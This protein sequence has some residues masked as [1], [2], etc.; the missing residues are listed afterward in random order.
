[1]TR[2]SKI[3]IHHQ[4]RSSSPFILRVRSPRCT[5][6]RLNYQRNKDHFLLRS[7][8]KIVLWNLRN[9]KS[10]LLDNL[11][12]S[13]KWPWGLR[14][15]SKTANKPLFPPKSK[16]CLTLP[17]FTS[18]KRTLSR[19][20]TLGHTRHLSWIKTLMKSRTLSWPSKIFTV[21]TVK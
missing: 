20:T 9:L 19:I 7:K 15:S 5:T 11:R 10:S 21:T 16:F 13:E 6:K 4:L 8:L 18:T 17:C 12:K 1:M 14:T 3:E 2:S